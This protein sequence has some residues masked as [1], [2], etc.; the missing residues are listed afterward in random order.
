VTTE[1]GQVARLIQTVQQEATP[2]Q[3]RLDHLGRWLAIA[4]LVLVVAISLLGWL[5]GAPLSV[6]LLTAISIGVAAVPEGL[7]AIVTISLTL[8]ARRMVRRNALIRKLPAVETLG[9]VTVICTDKTGTLTENRVRVVALQLPDEHLDVFGAKVNTEM[10]PAD[11]PAATFRQLLAAGALCNDAILKSTPNN[12]DSPANLGD[13]TEV[14]LLIAAEQFGITKESLE[15]SLPRVAELAF[16]SERKRMTTVH[17]FANDGGDAGRNNIFAITGIDRNYPIAVS[18]GSVEGLLDISAHLWVNGELAPLNGQW[19][20]RLLQ[21]NNNLAR[22]G[23]RVLGFA[24]R[25]LERIPDAQ[26][27]SPIERNLIFLGMMG[28]IDPPRADAASAVAQCRSA[29]IR[30]IMITGDHALTAGAI[31]TQLGF[32]CS[33]EIVTGAEME[34]LSAK[35][36]AVRTRNSSV[37]ARVSPSHKLR[38]V[39]ALQGQGQV[40]AMTGD[41]VNDAPA[42]KKADIG[43]AMGRSGTDVAKESA[44]MILL[45][46]NFSTIV[47]A[48]EEG[49]VIYDNVRKFIKY[50]LAT[51]SGEIWVMLLGPLMGMPLPLLPIQILWMNLVTDGLPALALSVEPAEADTMSRN[52]HASNES[53][54][55][56]GVGRHVMWVGPFMAAISLGVGFSYWHSGHSSWQTMIFSTLTLSQMAHVLAIR[57][58]RVSLFTAGLRS[59]TPLLG[60]VLLTALLQLIIVEFPILRSSFRTLGLSWHDWALSIFLSSLIFW[61]VEL[62]K[63]VIRR[64]SAAAS[65]LPT[66]GP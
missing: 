42:L 59:N 3:R 38:I 15:H 66:R 56:R 13:P 44:A 50:I 43:I 37:F 63:F 22:S 2:L 6:V 51:N 9:S 28:M 52:P 32:D 17:T 54:F 61:A 58:E 36:L 4:V 11:G 39:E 26:D 33:Q 12:G 5:R 48:V 27:F 31:A 10:E 35:E 20:Q 46:D 64:R 60:A 47:S 57:T 25:P 16:S 49:R 40:V 45:D 55:S 65:L 18:K 23:M 1:L 34:R 62:E 53:V 24:V 14:A 7:P 41:G 29:G 21:A 8:G 30:P 19:R